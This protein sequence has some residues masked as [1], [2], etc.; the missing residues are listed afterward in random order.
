MTS[1]TDIVGGTV[2]GSLTT[3]DCRDLGRLARRGHVLVDDAEPALLRHRDG[4]AGFRDGVHRGGHQGNVEGDGLREA[5][6]EADVAGNDEGVGGNEKDVVECQRLPDDTH[7]DFSSPQKR[8]IQAGFPFLKP[9]AD[10]SA[11][12]ETL[13]EGLSPPDRRHPP[14]AHRSN[15]RLTAD[16]HW[17]TLPL[18]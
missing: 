3:P 6:G 17:I 2:S 4:E 15:G 7:G 12:G 16:V 1:R 14:S 9:R 5:G 11:Q 10:P 8:I 18:S 13:P